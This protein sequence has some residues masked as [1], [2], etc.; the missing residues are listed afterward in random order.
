MTF[1]D[2]TLPP[3]FP[4]WLGH[5]ETSKSPKI[6]CKLENKLITAKHKH[7]L[8][9][10]YQISHI[11]VKEKNA[12]FLKDLLIVCLIV[13]KQRLIFLCAFA[14]FVVKYESVRFVSVW[15][16]PWAKGRVGGCPWLYNLCFPRN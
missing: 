6:S 16:S 13:G 12:T 4:S 9:Y 3:P 7:Y 10:L 14:F 5:A 11:L 15:S 1:Y 2:L 8:P